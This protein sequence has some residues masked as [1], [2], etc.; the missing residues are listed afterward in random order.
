MKNNFIY[1]IFIVFLLFNI[2]LSQKKEYTLTNQQKK[3]IKQAQSMEASGLMDEAINI[4]IN[5]LNDYPYIDEAFNSLKKIYI[6]NN[7]IQ[8]LVGVSDKY[9]TA[10]KFDPEKIINVFEIYLLSNT[11]KSDEVIGGI[12]NNKKPNGNL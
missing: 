2:S 9:I 8:D 6:I 1:S 12:L 5:L 11:K 7:N 4:Y 3:I 10:H